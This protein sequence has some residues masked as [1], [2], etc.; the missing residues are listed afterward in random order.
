MNLSKIS[1]AILVK[2]SEKTIKECLDA[3]KNFDEIILLDNLSDDNTLEIAK[4]F[5]NVKIYQSD[6]IG[7]GALKNLAISYA[8][9]DWILSID[10]DEV[11]DEDAIKSINDL[12]LDSHCVYALSRKNH[13]NGEW[14]KACGWYPDYVKRLFNKKEVSFNS[15]LVHESLNVPK[16]FQ[17]IKLKGSIKHYSFKDITQL[18]AKMQHYSS[19]WA[20]QNPHRF[21]S[22][23]IAILKG[24][25]TF[26]RNYL[27]K[28]GFLYG[29]RGFVISICNGLGAFFKY[30]KLYENSLTTPSVSLI[31]T[32]YNQKER[33]ALVLDSILEQK[34]MPNE[35]LIADDGSGEDTKELILDYQNKFPIPLK[36]IWQE[37]C[38]Y[39]LSKSRNHAISNAQGE[40]IIIVDGDMIL[41]PFFIQDH[42]KFAKKSCFIQGGRIIL[43]ELETQSIMQEKNHKKAL[44]K[45][46]F[47]NQRNLILSKIIFYLSQKNKKN[48]IKKDKLLSVRGC[49]MAFYK[50]DAYAINGFNEDFIGW[51]REDSE[52][53]V[54]FLN[55]GGEMRKLKFY[56]LAYH[57]YHQENSR[58]MLKENHQIYIQSIEQSKK[59]C[60]NGLLKDT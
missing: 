32:T 21:S 23:M 20:Q 57:L 50:E 31:V 29:Y 26:I 54:R 41:S 45:K 60:K 40:Y 27:F 25:W 43:N 38:G 22:P 16:N 51:G 28:R 52:F 53:V 44:N 9:N 48:G 35:V 30:M 37:D 56:A 4:Q 47:K 24:F 58:N 39:R 3:L 2:N 1:V 12:K 14:I 15:A 36:H 59:W 49:N 55:A 5:H 46:I 33:L 10:S 7:F 6:F 13:Y 34:L 11:L 17:E 8:K 42:L 18:L 19:L